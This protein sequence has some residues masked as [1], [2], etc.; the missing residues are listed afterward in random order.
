M[1]PTETKTP[2]PKPDTTVKKVDSAHS[3]ASPHGRDETP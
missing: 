3:P 2:E 1:N